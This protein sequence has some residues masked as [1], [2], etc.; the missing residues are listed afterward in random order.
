[1]VSQQKRQRSGHAEPADAQNPSHPVQDQAATRQTRRLEAGCPVPDKLPTYQELL[2]EALDMT[3]PASDPISPSAAM[4]AEERLQT[5]RDR[6]DWKLQREA[7]RTPGGDAPD[8][9]CPAPGTPPDRP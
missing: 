9:A 8:D 7:D 4:H 3:F 6:T 1:M 5:A 2:D